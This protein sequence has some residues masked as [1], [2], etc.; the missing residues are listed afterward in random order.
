MFYGK[1]YQVVQGYDSPGGS[2][3]GGASVFSI[4]ITLDEGQ[5]SG[6]YPEGPIYCPVFNGGTGKA[7]EYAKGLD[8]D[9]ASKIEENFVR[10]QTAENEF[11]RYQHFDK[12]SIPA[13]I[14]VGQPIGA[15]KPGVFV[16]PIDIAPTIDRHY[17]IGKMGLKAIH[18]HT[19]AGSG[20]DNLSPS[21][22]PFPIA[23]AHYQYLDKN[24]SWQDVSRGIPKTDQ[25]IRSL[26]MVEI[27]RQTASK[28]WT[29]FMPF[30]LNNQPHYLAY[31]SGDGTLSLSRIKSDG[32]GADELMHITAS[33]GWTNFM[34]F[35]LNNQPHYLAYKSGDGTLSLSRI[36]S[37]GKG[38]EELMH[39]TASKGWTNFMPFVLNNQPHYLAYK[40]I[41]RT[42]AI[43]RIKSNGNGVDELWQTK[44]NPDWSWSIFEPFV[45]N[46][47]P[48]YLSYKSG[49]GTSLVIS[50]QIRWQGSRGVDAY[51]Y[52][53]GRMDLD[54]LYA[55]ST[56]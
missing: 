10:I 1:R 38:V 2:H 39:I 11:V 35:V 40:Q 4:D 36:K 12:S 44:T 18:V 9:P 53:K 7:V 28:G 47:V 13:K 50:Y 52:S 17:I 45:L 51:R 29:N 30:V 24:D 41:D 19:S 33:K 43:S 22:R 27:F 5:D 16:I 54:E 31:K 23:F 8:P 49:D 3:N 37:D 34:P 48:H 25:K 15:T 26:F 6:I 32:K 42:L 55:I 20:R 14:D 46:G 56:K 21:G